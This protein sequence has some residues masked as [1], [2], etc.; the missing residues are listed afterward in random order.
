M[1]KS[2]RNFE[3]MKFVLAPELRE[4]LLGAGCVPIDV[5]DFLDYALD[6]FPDLDI[7]SME[8]STYPELWWLSDM[9]KD[10]IDFM[11]EKL[12]DFNGFT[13]DPETELFY[14]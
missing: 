3:Q 13:Y 4:V 5:F 8:R 2:H 10:D 6:Y 9:R 14:Y 1:F 11:S 12:A 7:S